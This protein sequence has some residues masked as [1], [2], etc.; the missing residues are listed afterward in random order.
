ML[1]D[2]SSTRLGDAATARADHPAA[3]VP[4]EVPTIDPAEAFAWDLNGYL[5]LRGLM[6]PDLLTAAHA[7]LDAQYDQVATARDRSRALADTATAEHQGAHRVG[8]KA[9]DELWADGSAHSA[10]ISGYP[11]MDVSNLLSLPLPHCLPFR[12]MA[13]RFRPFVSPQS[14]CLL[15]ISIEMAAFSREKSSKSP[16]FQSKFAVCSAILL[17]S[18]SLGCHFAPLFFFVRQFA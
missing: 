16:Q 17:Q 1:S 18:P 7:A 12:E 4:P 11:R 9:S 6:P 8:N 2:G 3:L 5:I 14:S 13:V 10:E 15:R